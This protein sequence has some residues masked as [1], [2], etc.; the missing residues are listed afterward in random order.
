MQVACLARTVSIR[1]SVIVPKS[2]A[3]IFLAGFA[4]GLV[5]FCVPFA[6][7][8]TIVFEWGIFMLGLGAL[9]VTL[10]VRRRV[11]HHHA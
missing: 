11:R 3:E 8:L 6:S 2:K 9:G 10:L 5:D 4:D 1:E 7:A